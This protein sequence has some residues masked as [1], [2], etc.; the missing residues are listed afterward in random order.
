M[1]GWILCV[2][3]Q[4]HPL[5]NLD[6]LFI[7]NVGPSDGKIK[8]LGAGLIPDSQAV[9]EPFGYQERNS[10]AFSFQQGIS[11][12]GCTHTDAL[13]QR[14]IKRFTAGDL[15]AGELGQNPA[16]AFE[17]SIVI[18]RRILG[19]KLDDNVIFQLAG[20]GVAHAVGERAAALIHAVSS[21]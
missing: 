20:A 13:D 7:E 14:G 17:R 9:L 18:V 1:T 11:G 19:K 21:Y 16:D 8:D 4:R 15:A 6:D 10:F 5:V 3:F 12:N 2:V